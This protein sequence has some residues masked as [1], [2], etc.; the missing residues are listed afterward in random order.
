MASYDTAE[1]PK[2]AKLNLDWEELYF[3]V[4]LMEE[5]IGTQDVPGVYWDLLQTCKKALEAIS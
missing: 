2:C 5:T 4:G 3:I 1:V